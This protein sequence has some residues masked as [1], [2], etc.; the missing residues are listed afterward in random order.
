MTIPNVLKYTFL[1]HFIA[2]MVFGVIFFLSPEFYV[3][4]TSWPFLD[5]AAGRVMGSAFLGFG[6][7]A[8]FGYRA[9]SWEEVKILS[10]GDIV[11]SLC[12]AIAMSWMMLAHPTIPALAGWFNAALM[13]FF[14]VL[15]LYSYYEAT[16]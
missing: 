4:M 3:D 6:V 13:G 5:P 1:L 7:A 14:F 10:I 15:F 12:G 9:A 16:R 2:C 11:L 8:L